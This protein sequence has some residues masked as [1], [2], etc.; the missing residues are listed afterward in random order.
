MSVQRQFCLVLLAKELQSK[1]ANT[2]VFGIKP[3]A[4]WVCLVFVA[5]A[6]ALIALILFEMRE[7]LPHLG[8]SQAYVQVH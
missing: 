6:C 2:G 5:N 8:K 1:F 7:H 4:H 3:C